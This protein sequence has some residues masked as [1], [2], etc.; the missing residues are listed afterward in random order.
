IPNSAVKP[1]SANDSVAV[2]HA[3][4]GNRQAL[5]ANPIQ[6]YPSVG[7]FFDFAFVCSIK[8]LNSVPSIF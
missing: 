3:K 7:F 6:V 2:C 5:I 4:V 8:L 1:L